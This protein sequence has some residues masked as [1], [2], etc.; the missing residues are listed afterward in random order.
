MIYDSDFLLIV[1]LEIIGRGYMVKANCNVLFTYV[2]FVEVN[3]CCFW[4]LFV[5]I[6]ED[7]MIKTSTCT[8]RRFHFECKIVSYGPIF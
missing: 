8:L 1:W 2:S 5:N 3:V 7:Y 6:L 4:A